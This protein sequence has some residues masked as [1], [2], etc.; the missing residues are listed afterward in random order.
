[1]NRVVI[2]FVIATILTALVLTNQWLIGLVVKNLFAKSLL[3]LILAFLEFFVII[4][5]IDH[6]ED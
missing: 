1:M 4:Q 6:G 5:I 2:A 3:S